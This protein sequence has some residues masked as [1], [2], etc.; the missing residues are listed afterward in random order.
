MERAL[1]FYMSAPGHRLTDRGLDSCVLCALR[2]SNAAP[3]PGCPVCA[4]SGGGVLTPSIAE[5]YADPSPYD[6]HGGAD[7]FV[8]TLRRAFVGWLRMYDDSM[9][10][11]YDVLG[12][13]TVLAAPVT[14]PNTGGVYR[15]RVPVVSTPTGWRLADGYDDPA[16]VQLV[17]LPWFQLVKL[18]GVVRERRSGMLRAWETKTSGTPEHFSADLL[19]DTQLPGYVRALWYASQR[20]GM[21]GG[22]EPG[23]WLWDVTSSTHQ[24]DPERLKS[25]LWSVRKRQRVPSWRWRAALEE[26]GE[27]GS[28]ESADQSVA[29]AAMLHDVAQTQHKR[30]AGSARAAGRGK[31]GAD[32]RKLRDAAGARL[33][34]AAEQLGRAE[35]TAAALRLQRDAAAHIDQALYVRRW[36]RFTAEDLH[37]YEVEL[38]AEATRLSGWLRAAP[39]TARLPVDADTRQRIALHWPR[40]PICRLPGGHC[41]YVSVC[42]NDSENGRENYQI[43]QQISWLNA[44]ALAAEERE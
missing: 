37:Q 38:F 21:F 10:E 25:K 33:K 14:S 11:D 1:R 7:L 26:S 4:G 44:A 2:S 31:S 23:G 22:A 39:G 42:L 30:R 28:I 41:P 9:A 5:I 19:L 40:V 13:Q 34:V 43:G 35:N 12:A 15:S 16:S 24:R 8:E 29:R 18:D 20:Y 36:G 17:S 27:W 32:A 3:L 6:E